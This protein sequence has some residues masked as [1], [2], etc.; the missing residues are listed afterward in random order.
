[1]RIINVQTFELRQFTS[2]A[3]PYAILSHK[4]SEEPSDEITFQD[5]KDLST[6]STKPGYAKI[7]GA[8]SETL[9]HGLEWLWVDTNC[10]D[11]GNPVELAENINPMF[12]FY[13]EAKV[14]FAYLRDV[15]PSPDHRYVQS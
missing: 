4:W 14:C 13:A 11:K 1:M 12:R 2:D 15:H 7:W 8:C 3:P 5:W 10:I 9:N 6:A